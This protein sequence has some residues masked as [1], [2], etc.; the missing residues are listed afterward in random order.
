MSKYDM[1]EAMYALTKGVVVPLRRSMFP[2][3]VIVVVGVAMFAVNVLIESTP[4]NANLKSALVLFATI[5]VGVGVVYAL[6]RRSGVPYHSKDCCFLSKKEYK[7]YKE[8]KAEVVDLV[9]R[10]DF[11]T[12]RCLPTDGVSAVTVVMYTSPKSNFCAVQVFEYEEMEIH[13]STELR[14]QA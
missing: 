4:D 9:K 2:P 8:R 1:R 3:L 11:T 12:L 6:T 14:W 5:L 13:P 7:F 10:G